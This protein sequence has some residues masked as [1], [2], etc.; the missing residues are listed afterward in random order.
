VIH[1]HQF[2]GLVHF[3]R[4]LERVGSAL[5]QHLLDLNLVVNKVRRGLGFG[6]WSVAS[7]LKAKTKSSVKFV[8][9]YEQAMVQMAHKHR[10]QGVICGHIHK[11]EVKRMGDLEYFNCGDWVENCTALVEDLDGDISLVKHYESAVYSAGGGTRPSDAGA[12]RV[13]H[14]EAASAF[15]GGRDRRD[16]RQPEL[17]RLF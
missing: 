14:P 12:G 1:G 2:D 11:P 17:A 9:R 8:T 15:A 5:Y 16:A 7:Y 3:N 4:L 13:G 10:V 6:Y